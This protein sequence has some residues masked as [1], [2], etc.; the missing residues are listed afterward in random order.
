MKKIKPWSVME[1]DVLNTLTKRS[2]EPT[3]MSFSVTEKKL[4]GDARWTC[5]GNP[6]HNGVRVD[7]HINTL[8]NS[9]ERLMNLVRFRNHGQFADVATAH[10]YE[11]WREHRQNREVGFIYGSVGLVFYSNMG[12]ICNCGADERHGLLRP[13]LPASREAHNE[14][15]NINKCT[16]FYD[17]ETRRLRIDG[18][19]VD[20]VPRTQLRPGRAQPYDPSGPVHSYT[21]RSILMDAV[22]R[23]DILIDKELLPVIL[24]DDLEVM[25]YITQLC[26]CDSDTR[27]Q[28]WCE[29]YLNAHEDACPKAKPFARLFFI[30]SKGESNIKIQSIDIKWLMFPARAIWFRGANV[31]E[32]ALL[33]SDLNALVYQI[34]KMTEEENR[35]HDIEMLTERE[36]RRRERDTTATFSGI[37]FDI[38]PEEQTAPIQQTR[39]PW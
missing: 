4:Q 10:A 30:G 39:Q 37:T 1:A 13:V 6:D 20:A 36:R 18:V 19:L 28:A 2:K 24:H 14:S 7:A 16:S 23:K 26:T 27:T 3:V 32:K 5:H 21:I 31:M 12:I 11:Y 34:K 17:K 29:N 35:A 8:A 9:V 22:R 33:E 15:C 38:L 25:H